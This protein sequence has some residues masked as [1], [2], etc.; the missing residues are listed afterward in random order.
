MVEEHNLEGRTPWQR[1][2]QEA[3]WSKDWQD[4]RKFFSLFWNPG[5]AFMDCVWPQ[6]TI[7]RLLI[8]NENRE[9]IQE[10][11][12]SN[13]QRDGQLPEWFVTALHEHLRTTDMR[14]SIRKF[15]QTFRCFISEQTAYDL[16]AI[17]FTRNA[18]GHSYIATGQHLDR[19]TRFA[20]F[21]RYAP[22]HD[23]GFAED[24]EDILK[25]WTITAD[26]NWMAAHSARVMR[27]FRVCENIAERLGI[28]GGMIY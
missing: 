20:A 26:E 16:K 8:F 15:R 17:A 24:T 22:R 3:E 27:I 1:R 28:P 7:I 10:F 25:E 19:R 11:V 14:P 13:G 9:R 23:G 12:E 6:S 2:E 18:I 5:I 4:E 21:L